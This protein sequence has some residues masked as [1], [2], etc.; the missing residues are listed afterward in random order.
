MDLNKMEIFI[1][2]VG[3]PIALCVGMFVLMYYM[4][5]T[6]MEKQ[7]NTQEQLTSVIVNNTVALQVLMQKVSEM[8]DERKEEK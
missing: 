3:F 5:K 4:L 8:H 1:S 6:E 7:K 2:N